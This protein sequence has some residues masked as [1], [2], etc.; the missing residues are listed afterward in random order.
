MKVVSFAV[1]LVT[2]C[3]PL[4]S[5]ENRGTISGSVTD[6]TGAAVARAKVT[7]TESRTGVRTT[8]QSESSGAYT[9]PFLAL[10]EYNISAE[11][12]GFKKF[13]QSGIT[14]SAG[15][16]PVIDIHL[17]VGAITESVEVHEDAPILETANPTVGQVITLEEV[18]NFPV[19]GR[20]PMML[21]NLAMGVISTYEPGPVRPFDNGAPNSISIGGAPAARNEVLLNGAPN[22]GFSNQMAYL[23]K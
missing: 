18:E 14:L 5:Q 13:V 3:S 7:A 2:A 1:L 6:A 15:A 12:T 19:N 4:F 10:G 21:A 16:H 11:A 23:R 9:I 17:D 20:T 8:V 22:A